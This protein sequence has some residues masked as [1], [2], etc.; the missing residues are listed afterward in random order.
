MP[1]TFQHLP[2]LLLGN[3]AALQRRCIL[4]VLQQHSGIAPL[5]GSP[6][7]PTQ[8]TLL[9]AFLGIVAQACTL[10]KKR[11]CPPAS[12][13]QRVIRKQKSASM[14][15][16]AKRGAWVAR[17][18]PASCSPGH[19]EKTLAKVFRKSM[20]CASLLLHL[21]PPHQLPRSQLP[22]HAVSACETCQPPGSRPNHRPQTLHTEAAAP[23]YQYLCLPSSGTHC[24]EA[25]CRCKVSVV[26]Y[27]CEGSHQP[28]RADWGEVQGSSAEDAK[29]CSHGQR[30]VST[31]PCQ[32]SF[33]SLPRAG[34]AV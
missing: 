13:I 23:T 19:F 10:I 29:R 18:L 25:V 21:P 32:P 11:L 7:T 6:T 17:S 8:M 22:C 15:N 4:V 16:A 9:E 2:V 27:C 5:N 1:Q 20:S 12:I 31:C 3:E 24:S 26:A 33:R 34:P 14:H 28:D 30:I